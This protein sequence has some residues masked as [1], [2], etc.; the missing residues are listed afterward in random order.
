[1][2]RIESVMRYISNRSLILLL[3]VI[4]ILNVYVITVLISFILDS[5]FSTTGY[6]SVM[7]IFIMG[8]LM[9]GILS[10]LFFFALTNW[11][12]KEKY[13]YAGSLIIIQIIL[14]IGVV[15]LITAFVLFSMGY[16]G[17]PSVLPIRE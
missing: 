17:D 9:A 3:S 13:L 4:S 11:V 8:P 7:S 15:A 14:T 16:F 6:L 2:S 1:M 10:L 12:K 5:R